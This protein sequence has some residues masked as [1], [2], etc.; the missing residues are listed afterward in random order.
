M[1]PYFFLIAL[2]FLLGSQLAFSQENMPKQ[3]L[4]PLAYPAIALS[5][6][7]AEQIFVGKKSKYLNC[8][9]FFESTIQFTNSY[10]NAVCDEAVIAC[11]RYGLLVQ[12]MKT[13]TGKLLEELKKTLVLEKVE[14]KM[15]LRGCQL[16]LESS[17]S[18][19]RPV[20]EIAG[21]PPAG[22]YGPAAQ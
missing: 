4:S 21:Y 20:P 22:G 16:V 14:V 15:K 3:N 7:L 2:C 9:A 17:L 13:T 11:L 19:T 18:D 12:K 1:K 5:K 10:A 6:E 8:P